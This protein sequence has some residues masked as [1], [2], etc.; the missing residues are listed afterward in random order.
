MPSWFHERHPGRGDTTRA[1]IGGRACRR[2]RAPI[3][4]RPRRRRR[5]GVAPVDGAVLSAQGTFLSA[6]IFDL[7]T[8]FS[9]KLFDFYHYAGYDTRED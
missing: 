8:S 3:A 6:G 4:I 1:P 9:A 5:V 2:R 7:Q